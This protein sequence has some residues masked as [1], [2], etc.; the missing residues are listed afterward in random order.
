VLD[1]ATVMGET[2]MLGLRLP[3]E[4]VS[5]EAFAARHGRRLEDVYGTE[6]EDLVRLG[7]VDWDGSRVQLTARGLMVANV[8]EERFLPHVAPATGR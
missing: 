6:L 8:V 1:E 7:L 3:G 2:M 5:A 4:G